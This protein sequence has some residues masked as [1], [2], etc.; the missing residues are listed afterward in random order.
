QQL[1]P[2]GASGYAPRSRLGIRLRDLSMRQMTRRPMRNVLAAQ[3]AKAGNIELPAYG[4]GSQLTSRRQ[5][6][7]V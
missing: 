5:E 1:P 3:F 7:G 4:W 6:F 2:G